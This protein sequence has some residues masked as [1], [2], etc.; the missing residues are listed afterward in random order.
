MSSRDGS[1]GSGKPLPAHSCGSHGIIPIPLGPEQPRI[2]PE[3]P[4][5]GHLAGLA[6]RL[7][8]LAWRLN[9]RKDAGRVACN[10]PHCSPCHAAPDPIG[11]RMPGAC[12]LASKQCRFMTSG[13]QAGDSIVT[14]GCQ[15]CRAGPAWCSGSAAPGGSGLVSTARLRIQARRARP[16]WCSGSAAARGGAPCRAPCR[17][18]QEASQQGRPHRPYPDSVWWAEAGTRDCGP[19]PSTP[20]RA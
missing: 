10:C 2:G 1:R 9:K 19:R 14:S 4:R 8:C 17:P 13:R 5:I 18:A 15:G 20:A 3:Q 16:A 7:N 12:G 6:W 11:P